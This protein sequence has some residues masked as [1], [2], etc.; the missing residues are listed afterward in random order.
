MKKIN[1]NKKNFLKK[2]FIKL[3]RLFGFEIIDQSN[4][5]VVTSNKFI[6]E[7]LSIP[8]KVSTNLPLGRVQITRSI[9]S[10]DVILRT[11]MSVN[12]LTQ[13]KNR[14]FEKNKEEYTKR[15]L[16]SLVNNI[17]HAKK[18]FKN[19]NFKFYI[20]DH[21]SSNDQLK[22]IRN[23]LDKSNINF[24]IMKLEFEKFS[25]YIN[26]INQENKKVTNNQMS[27][28]S[29]I[30][31]SLLLSKEKSEDLTY[32]V[33]DD[34]IHEK[35]C[36]S[37]ILFA[38]ERISSL[39]KKELVICPSDYPYLYTN[40]EDTKIYLGQNYHWRKVDQTLCTF[41]TSKKIIEKYWNE[42]I[43]M[44]KVEHY[45]FEKPLHSIYK[46]ELCISPMPSLALHFTNVNSIY[47]L[48]PNVNWKRLWEENEN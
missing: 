43:S 8:G 7:N 28:M 30:H 32:F 37:E 39:I 6:N 34:Y 3:C 17:N 31:Q 4:F 46:K 45:P 12:M 26:P 38:Y 14:M 2:I 29:N 36:L 15:T 35:N 11:C 21:N 47:G 22:I 33:E 23:I 9:K 42:L 25:K 20:I 10:L 5:T 19:V 1:A 44:C 24:E 40:D 16:I 13:S 48:S 18:I 41:L 27:N